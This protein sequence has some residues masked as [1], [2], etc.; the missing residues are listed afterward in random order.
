MILLTS[1]IKT[2]AERWPAALKL[3]ALALVS[4]LVVIFDSIPVL[5]AA[6]VAVCVLYALPGPAFLRAGLRA[7]R[8]LIPFI[9]L[10]AVW[11]L[12]TGDL[13]VGLQITLRMLVLVG[14][15]NLVTMT[16]PLQG[17]VDVVHH[18]G[19]PFRAIG[20]RTRT[21]E[22]ALPLVIRFTPVLTDKATQLRQAWRARSRRRPG[23]RI[24]FPLVIQALDDAD[25]VAEALRA[26]GGLTDHNR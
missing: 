23:W 22:I 13:Q 4:V 17:L 7:L 24:V 2:R 11:H 8:M 26:R 14:L 9:L 19:A 6:L 20:L 3:A 18:L 16:T 10:L 5:L 1:P 12:W 21:V 25:H 15:A